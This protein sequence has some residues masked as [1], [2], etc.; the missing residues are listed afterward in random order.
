MLVKLTAKQVAEN[1][2]Y[3]KKSFSK[4]PEL[5]ESG[6]E[7]LFFS[8]MLQDRIQVWFS[9]GNKDEPKGFLTTYVIKNDFGIRNVLMVAT[10]I[11]FD[12]GEQDWKDVYIGLA[13]FAKKN[14]CS[15]VLAFTTNETLLVRINSLEKKPNV[16][17]ALTWEV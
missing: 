3:I 16:Q 13:E 1:W 14:N 7:E 2:K 8:G 15:K 11:A 10:A 17:L 9:V 4:F 12:M 5:L 6:T